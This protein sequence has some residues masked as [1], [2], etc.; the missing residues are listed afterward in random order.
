MHGLVKNALHEDWRV[1]RPFEGSCPPWPSFGAALGKQDMKPSVKGE[2]EP[3]FGGNCA[4]F[5]WSANSPIG[6]SCGSR[7]LPRTSR[8][9]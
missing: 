3:G 8:I 2:R 6:R 4:L 5:D 9:S 1:S 7:R